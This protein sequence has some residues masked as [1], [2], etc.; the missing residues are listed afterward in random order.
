MELT[1]IGTYCCLGVGHVFEGIYSIRLSRPED[2]N[3]LTARLVSELLHAL[4]ALERLEDCKM[5]VLE[6]AGGYFCTGMNLQAFEDRS[7]DGKDYSTPESPQ[8]MFVMK[9]IAG[10]SKFV[11]GKVDGQALAGG[12]GLAAA[13][14]YVIATPRST[15][16]LPEAI[17]GLVPAL[18]SP[19]LIRRIGYWQAYQMTLT[20]LPLDAEEALKCR[21][22]DEVT[23]DPDAAIMKLYRRVSRVSSRTMREIKQYFKQMW[24]IN[25]AMENAAIEEI[26]KLTASH[27]VRESI[28][29]YVRYK[30]FPWEK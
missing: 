30:R 22:A 1:E 10:M 24:I 18:I 28:Q 6:G 11:I 13:C 23:A 9:T 25:E 21:L 14:D 3:S 15:F 19:Y 4:D 17:W 16:A 29:N 2:K 7:A 5:V 26:D 20:T 27:E 12:V 8:F